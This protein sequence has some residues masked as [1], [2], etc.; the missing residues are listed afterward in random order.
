MSMETPRLIEGGL[1]VDDRGSL[2]FINDLDLDE[3]RRFYVVS[4]HS[5]GFVRAWHYHRHERKYVVV[6]Q[7]AA[8]VQAVEVDAEEAP[9]RDM[10]IHRFVLSAER[11][12][13]LVIPP[14]YAHGTMTLTGDAKIVFF[15][16]F[17]LPQSVDDDIR[18]A[19][20]Y[21]GSWNV[22]WR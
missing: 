21:W 14:G 16:N 10:E 2:S 4:N 17:T 18:Y 7:G 3:V 1:A 13:A 5:A 11:P 20:D 12:S 9:S 6:L 19:A 8:L 22:S 15:S